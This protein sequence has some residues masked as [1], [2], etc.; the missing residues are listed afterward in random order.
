MK[1]LLSFLKTSFLGGLL[2]VLPAWLAV[3]LLLKL[4]M[5]LHIFVKPV[6]TELPP[7]LAHPR[8]IA[9]LLLILFCFLVGAL[10]QTAIGAQLKNLLEKT[11]LDKLPGYSTLRSFAGQLTDFEKTDEFKPALVEIEEAL[12][13]GFLIEQHPG[14]RCTVFIPSAPTPMAGDIYIIARR[15]VHLVNVSMV[16]MMKCI[17][18]W[19]AGSGKLI[20]ALDAGHE[21]LSGIFP[22]GG[23]S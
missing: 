12:V 7:S 16:T 2:L 6:T 18:K 3:L 8:I 13:P 23:K 21:D 1:Q 5:Q 10:I 9:T 19:G 20:E 15:R 17:S 11:V 4:V 14:E 22:Q